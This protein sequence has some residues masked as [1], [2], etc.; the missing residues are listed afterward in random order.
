MSD[1]TKDFDRVGVVHLGLGA[2]FRAFGLPQLQRMQAQLGADHAIGWDVIGISLR[3]AGVR[4]LLAQNGFRYHA[5]EMDAARRLVEEITILKAVYFLEDERREVLNALLL[6][7]L[8]MVTL[9]ITE[10]EYR[11]QKIEFYDRKNS[12][13]KTLS[14]A[15]YNKFL[16][17]Y[18][19]ADTLS[20]EN[21]Q[22]GKKT[23][24]QFSDWAF[25]TGMTEKDFQKNALKRIK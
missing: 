4:D 17:K 21:H 7:H 6:P 23:Q 18:W 15:D 3:S 8:N 12:L 19:R 22:T 1:L 5:V 9:T 25:Q 2:F 16:G 10:K 13:L 14:Y 20:M 11:L 24:L